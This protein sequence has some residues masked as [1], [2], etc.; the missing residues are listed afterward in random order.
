MAQNTSLW[1]GVGLAAFQYI[2]FSSLVAIDNINYIL[3]FLSTNGNNKQGI[4]PF[5]KKVNKKNSI[6]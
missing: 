2:Y 5:S 6:I 4:E 3:A 1:F